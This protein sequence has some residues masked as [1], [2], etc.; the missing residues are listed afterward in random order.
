MNGGE[1]KA[2]K[3]AGHKNATE[4]KR[5]T[6]SQNK[7]LGIVLGVLCVV[8]VGLTIGVIVVKVNEQNAVFSECTY[9]ETPYEIDVC[10]SENY[11]GGEDGE[12]DNVAGAIRAY[13][14]AIEKAKA[15]NNYDKAAELLIR[16]TNK[17][18]LM[19]VCEDAMDLLG[20]EDFGGYSR[21]LLRRIYSNAISTSI[22]CGDEAAQIEWNEAME[23]VKMT[24]EEEDES[25]W[26]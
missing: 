8:I 6:L 11:S 20:E 21:Q 3:E 5:A 1:A 17:L 18:A 22:D 19:D 2:D 10:I 13:S 4:R 9:K 15:E 25:F 12:D 16:R 24:K 26:Q 7:I 23:S 14:E